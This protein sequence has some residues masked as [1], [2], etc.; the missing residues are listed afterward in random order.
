[1]FTPAQMVL[2]PDGKK[3]HLSHG[4]IDIILQ[5]FGLSNEVQKSYEQVIKFFP[6]I[7]PDLVAEIGDLRRPYS[8]GWQ[9]EGLVSRRMKEACYP[10]QGKFLTPMAAVAGAVAD[11]VLEISLIN[12]KLDKIYVNNG[13]DISFHLERG[14]LLTAGIVG[15]ISRSKINGKCVFNFENPARGIATSGWKG[16]SFSMGIADAVTVLAS[17]AAAADVAATLIANAVFADHPAIKQEP[18]INQD[19]DSDLGERLITVKVGKLD[20]NTI[21]NALDS[22]QTVAE[23]MELAGHI[24]AAVLVLQDSF[25]VVGSP[26]IGLKSS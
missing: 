8:K 7:L 18:A 10:Y 26:P 9:P 5:S 15:D 13:G 1:M 2:T 17:N 21:E 20:G 3:L 25:R 23:Q 12:R 22:G 19:I 16:R 6:K 24:T 11:Q 4:P 14:H